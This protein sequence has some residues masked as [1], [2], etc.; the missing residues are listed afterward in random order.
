MTLEVEPAGLRRA[1]TKLYAASEALADLDV[2]TAGATGK[3]FGHVELAA[4]STTILRY[5]QDANSQLSDTAATMAESLRVTADDLEA[6]DQDTS[7]RFNPFGK[8]GDPFLQLPGNPSPTPG[9]GPGTGT[10]GP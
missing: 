6:R 7:Q 8:I 1:A 5:C 4:W 2:R 10:A 3:A 9:T